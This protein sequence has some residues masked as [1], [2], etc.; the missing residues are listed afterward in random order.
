[1]AAK[2]VVLRNGQQLIS[3]VSECVKDDMVIGY[4]LE[5]PCLIFMADPSVRAE[6]QVTGQEKTA[7]DVS[8]FP[9]IPLSKETDILVPVDG[10]LTFVDPVDALLTMYGVPEEKTCEDE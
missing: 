7:L 6:I 5:K 8:L 2:I 9:W 10:V 4:R 1:M 3:N